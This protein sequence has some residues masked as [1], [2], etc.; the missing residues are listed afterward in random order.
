MTYDD[1]QT[2]A[3]PARRRVGVLL[4]IIALH[5][6]VLAWAVERQSASPT[7]RAGSSLVT[8]DVA[9]A[10]TPPAPPLEHR[11]AP[12]SAIVQPLPIVLPPPALLPVAAVTTVEDAVPEGGCDLTDTVQTALRES[13]AARASIAALPR[14]ERSVANAI[15]L[16]DGHWVGARS[17]GDGRIMAGIR[18]V[19]RA[20]VRA[21]SPDCRAQLQAG[22]RLIVLP[23][24]PDVVLALGS[25]RWR[26]NDLALDDEGIASAKM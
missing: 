1:V 25:G 6:A 18:D 14:S 13:D 23:G 2:P 26:W 16:W 3:H 19:V 22:P 8:F 4:P 24:A 21:A 11:S 17:P 15:M 12:S 5:V 10:P 9:P 20:T 7:Q